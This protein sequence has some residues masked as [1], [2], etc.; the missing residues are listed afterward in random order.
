M[1]QN[2]FYSKRKI[3]DGKEIVHGVMVHGV[4]YTMQGL[5]DCNR[6]AKHKFPQ[7]EI[8]FTQNCLF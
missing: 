2:Q 5:H 6:Q 1:L 4:I 8:G 3:I 7:I